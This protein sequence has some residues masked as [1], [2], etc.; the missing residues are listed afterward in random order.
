MDEIK[1]IVIKDENTK[2][3][4]TNLLNETKQQNIT[5]KEKLLKESLKDGLVQRKMLEIVGETMIEM[6]DEI[7]EKDNII[8]EYKNY[9]GDKTTNDK[10]MEKS[11]QSRVIR[12]REDFKNK[13]G[14]RLIK[15]A[16]KCIAYK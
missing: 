12:T 9:I 1:E 8:T 11:R 10:I 16:N 3:E 6:Q 15:N 7:D 4:L 2:I 5:T 14:D 13:I